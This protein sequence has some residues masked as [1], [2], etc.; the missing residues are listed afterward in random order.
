[1]SNDVVS[2]VPLNEESFFPL[3]KIEGRFLK[4]TKLPF[5]N[6]VYWREISPHQWKRELRPFVSASTSMENIVAMAALGGTVLST[7]RRFYRV[8]SF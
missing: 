4:G 6:Y 2:P 1:M 7:G 5:I 3:K 8:E